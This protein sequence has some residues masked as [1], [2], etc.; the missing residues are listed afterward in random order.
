[1]CKLQK[2]IIRQKKSKKKFDNKNL[3]PLWLD[4]FSLSDF[5][6]LNTYSSYA[7]TMMII[8]LQTN[9][10]RAFKSHRKSNV[11]ISQPRFYSVVSSGNIV[12]KCRVLTSLNNYR[13]CFLP[14]IRCNLVFLF[15]FFKCSISLK[16]GCL[17][18]PK[19]LYMAFMVNL[20]N[21][22]STAV[23]FYYSL[24]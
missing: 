4:F 11:N 16:F 23:Y 9:L 14:F 8:H 7:I 10:V 18:N 5:L 22:K 12:A 2:P 19:I 21:V 13:F 15:F 24:V 17:K 1:M 6:T 20:D 3:C